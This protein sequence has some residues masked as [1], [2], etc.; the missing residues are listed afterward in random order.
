MNNPQSA[1]DKLNQIFSLLNFTEDK[2]KELLAELLEG[3]VT[4]AGARTGEQNPALLEKAEELKTQDS[5]SQEALVDMFDNATKDAFTKELQTL[6]NEYIAKLNSTVNDDK[7]K[8][9]LEIW[10]SEDATFAGTP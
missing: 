9:I 8:Q 1:I 4:L 7:K 10:N 6:L 3:V 2:K 5:A